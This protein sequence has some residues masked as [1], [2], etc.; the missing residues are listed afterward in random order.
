MFRA[1]LENDGD[2]FFEE[3]HF[4]EKGVSAYGLGE[5]EGV[6]VIGGGNGEEAASG[7]EMVS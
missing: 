6:F 1:E 4:V 7:L 2:Q 3:F 5:G